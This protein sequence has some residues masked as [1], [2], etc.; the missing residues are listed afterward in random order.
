M[1][2]S[3]AQQSNA[4]LR[5]IVP[6]RNPLTG[7]IETT[8]IEYEGYI[9]YRGSYLNIPKAELIDLTTT[10]ELKSKLQDSEVHHSPTASTVIASMMEGAK[11]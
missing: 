6:S 7:K 8:Q 10:E 1:N 9:A 5:M 3:K 4:K 11:K 2:D